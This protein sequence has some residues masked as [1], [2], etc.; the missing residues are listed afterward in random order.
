[1]LPHFQIMESMKKFEAEIQM[2]RFRI[3]QKDF[4]T[5]GRKKNKPL[6]EA[7]TDDDS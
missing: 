4:G 2:F 1:M 6:L 7:S 3:S 5:R